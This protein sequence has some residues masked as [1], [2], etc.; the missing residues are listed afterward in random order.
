M[1]SPMVPCHCIISHPEEPK[2]LVIRHSNG[3]SPPLLQVPTDGTLM[4]KPAVI[5]QGMMKKYGLRTTVLRHILSAR[6]YHCIELELHASSPRN[7]QAVWVDRDNYA[8][9]R[10]QDAGSDDPFEAWLRERE[11]GAVPP[12]RSPWERPGW[13]REAEQWLTDR[14]VE[15]DIQASGS[16]QQFKAGVPISC[17][18]RVAT[19][20]GQIYFKAGYPKPP[21]EVRLTRLLADRW[22]D[23]VPRPL[24]TDENRN[25]MVMR[26]FGMKKE[27]RAKPAHYPEFARAL[28]RFQIEAADDIGAF[29]GIS[30]PVMDLDFLGNATGVEDLLKRV[31]PLLSG[32]MRALDQ[33]EMDR[34]RQA[35]SRSPTACAELGEYQIAN[36]L[37]HLDYRPDNWF[38]EGGVCRVMDWADVVI[39]HPFMSLCQALSFFDEH[40]TGEPGRADATPFDDRKKEAMIKAYLDVFRAHGSSQNLDASLEVA[41]RVYPLLRFCFVASELQ[42]LEDQGPHNLEV[43]NLL[44]QSARMLISDA[45]P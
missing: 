5:N 38:V 22:P 45:N 44:K 16:I 39:S 19:A 20:R 14:L 27:N 18:L 10:R 33:T 31:E 24:A 6:N 29:A 1:A 40:G 41:S 36:S 32:G 15:L 7:L 23:L 28:A 34:L 13:Y 9:F 21:G 30:C 3:W 25:W 42:Y 17:I 4:Y 12:L 37:A 8:Q 11:S 26:D 35:I 43:R 2:F